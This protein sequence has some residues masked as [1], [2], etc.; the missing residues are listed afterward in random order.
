MDVPLLKKNLE[1]EKLQK[2][3]N[4]CICFCLNLPQR[5]CTDPLH[6]RIENYSGDRVEDCVANTVFNPLVPGVH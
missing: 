4:K 5:S 1:N 3:Q 2:A 6:F